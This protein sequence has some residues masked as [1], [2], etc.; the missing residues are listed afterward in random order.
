M[1][2]RRREKV[3]LMEVLIRFVGLQ[4]R[5]R[6]ILPSL[7]Q[8]D[9]DVVVATTWVAQSEELFVNNPRAY[10]TLFKPKCSKLY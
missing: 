7:G 4:D 2:S 1:Y 9:A 8:R 10:G 3:A 6:R 5:W